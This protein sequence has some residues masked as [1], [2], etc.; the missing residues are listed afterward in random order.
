M[1]VLLRLAAA[2]RSA[3]TAVSCLRVSA[4][5]AMVL[6]K[7]TCSATPQ[8]QRLSGG[9]W[10]VTSNPY[11]THGLLRHMLV[12]AGTGQKPVEHAVMLYGIQWL[13]PALP[14]VLRPLG[15]AL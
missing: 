4:S 7:A 13:P 6:S 3:S 15:S 1:R 14:A 2:V 11:F 9:Q 12:I 10:R 5:S 8:G